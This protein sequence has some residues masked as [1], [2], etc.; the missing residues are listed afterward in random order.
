MA[1]TEG[2]RSNLYTEQPE[3]KRKM[4]ILNPQLSTITLN[5]NGLNL[6]VKR[7]TVARWINKQKTQ[8]MLPTRHSPVLKTIRLKLKV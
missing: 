4:A 8:Y 7:Q 5:V 1:E 6:S 2:K 3:N